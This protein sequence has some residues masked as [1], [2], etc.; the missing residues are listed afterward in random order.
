MR[1]KIELWSDGNISLPRGYNEYLQALI[2][3]HLN[4]REAKWLHD[5]GYAF[6][7]RRFRLFVISDILEKGKFDNTKKVMN[8]R[9]NISFYVSSPVDW[10]LEQIAKNIINS[11]YVLLGNNRLRVNSVGV[12]K[13]PVI[14]NGSV[15]V[16]TLSPVEV[17]STFER[18]GGGKQTHYY[19]PFEKQFEELVNQNIRKKWKAFYKEDCPYMLKI[20]PL[21]KGNRN[22]RI[23]FFGAGR[24]KTVIKGWEGFFRI[25]GDPQ[26]LAFALDAGIGSRNS[27]GFGMVEVV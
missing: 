1:I 27:Q 3:G 9:R 14:E 8:Y 25:E 16:K 19:S 11:E 21:F 2:Y 24:D 13:S 5:K 23:R 26:L 6:E 20:R 12:M 7:N 10:I 18:E 22:E 17:H 15:K 4:D